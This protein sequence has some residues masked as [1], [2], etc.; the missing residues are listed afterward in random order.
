MRTHLIQELLSNMKK[1]QFRMLGSSTLAV[2]P[3]Q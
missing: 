3:I 1:F 2:S